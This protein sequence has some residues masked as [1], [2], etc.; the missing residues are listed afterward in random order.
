MWFGTEG[1]ITRYRRD[2]TIR[3]KVRINSVTA[4]RFYTDLSQ[5]PAFT[6]GTRVT[7]E[8]SAIDFKTI[9]EKQQYRCR[10]C[11]TQDPRH[12]TQDKENRTR[13]SLE[14]RVLSLGSSEA[15]SPPTKET[16]FDWIPEKPGT[17]TF[18]VQAIDR[19]LNY[20]EPVTLDLTVQ[21]DPVFA[22]LQSEVEHLRRE[23]GQ[24]YDFQDIIGRSTGIRQ[25]RALMERAI[26][27][28]LTVLVTGE[29]GTGKELVAKAIH[30]NSS[31]KDH[32]FLDRNCGAIPKELLASELFGHR[33]G[34]F[35]GAQDDKMGLFEAA[36]GGT[37]LLDEISEMTQD[38]QIHLLRVLEER[39]VQRLGEHTSRDVD[40]RI[41]AMTNRDLM[42]EVAEGR[43]REDLY[44]RLSEFPIPIPPLRER[45]EDIPLLAEHFLQRYLHDMDKELGFA[46]DVF[47]MLQSYSWPG[48]VR[49]LGNAIRRAAALAE[50]GKQIQTYHFSSV[51]TQGESLVQEIISQQTG[52]SESLNNFRRR[53]VEEALQK[54]N[55]NRTQAA[56]LLKMS[57]PNLVTMIKRLGIDS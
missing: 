7:V 32:P 54:C 45:V 34:A 27:S 11:E 5:L 36:S 8:Y 13:D 25:V 55:G 23:V 57:R 37:V 31:R 30:Y 39:K 2:T 51:I 19:D 28:G 46:P 16:T 38:A 47:E 40:V 56:K 17:Y 48:N 4:D 42:E 49:E 35:T 26:D 41:I 50:E 44:Y 22:A 20:S 12:K 43:F 24:K 21:P 33:K 53:L 10:V 3:P 14:S 15:H 1:G 6:S 52:Y 9:P 18:Q 29:T